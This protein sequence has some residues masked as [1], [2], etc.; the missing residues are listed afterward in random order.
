[1]TSLLNFSWSA[2]WVFVARPRR[3]SFAFHNPEIAADFGPGKLVRGDKK[4]RRTMVSRVEVRRKVVLVVIR[5]MKM[6]G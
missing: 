1:M 4:R 2:L 6:A 5:E 3:A